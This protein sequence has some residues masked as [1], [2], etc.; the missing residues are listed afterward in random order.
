M[1]RTIDAVYEHGVLRPLEPLSLV[2][3]QRVKLTIT[4][5][6]QVRSQRDLYIVEQ[7]IGEIAMIE[8]IPS[9][10]EVRVALATIPGSASQDVIAERGD[11]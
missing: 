10:E 3:S 11:Y 4:D 5:T 2:E 9:I 7:A 6:L 1:M 8:K